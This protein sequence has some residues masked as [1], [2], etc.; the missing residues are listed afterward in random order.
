MEIKRFNKSARMS[1]AV[2]HNGTVYLSGIVPKDDAADIAG[3]T[4]QVLEAIEQR[5][6]AAGSDK[7]RLLSA[8]VLLTDMADFDGMN[9]V[10]EAWI[11]PANPPARMTCQARLARATMRIEIMAIAAA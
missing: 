9:A 2:V 6:A 10:W 11:D 7:S 1:Q 4:R 8:Q 5:L 3:Q